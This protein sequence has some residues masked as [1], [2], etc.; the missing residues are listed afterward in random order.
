MMI[1]PWAVPSTELVGFVRLGR[2]RSGRVIE[3]RDEG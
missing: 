1:S 2:E 3:L